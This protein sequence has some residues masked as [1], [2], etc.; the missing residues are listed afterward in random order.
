MRK[1]KPRKDLSGCRECEV[2]LRKGDKY[3][4][5]GVC[6]KCGVLKS[7]QHMAVYHTPSQVAREDEFLHSC[8]NIDEVVGT[9]LEPAYYDKED[10]DI[11][12]AR[13]VFLSMVNDHIEG[14]VYVPRNLLTLKNPR[15]FNILLDYFGVNCTPLTY[16]DIGKK[17]K[18]TRER[19]RQIVSGYSYRLHYIF[20]VH[21]IVEGRNKCVRTKGSDRSIANRNDTLLRFE[22]IEEE[23][24][25]AQ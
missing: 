19:A 11:D 8:G 2:K 14:K 4:S 5:Q 10:F 24:A 25:N 22:S 13:E 9:D 18:I 15:K 17:Y 12:A 6:P 1:R 21:I 23:L 7:K 3:Y 16:E 20:G